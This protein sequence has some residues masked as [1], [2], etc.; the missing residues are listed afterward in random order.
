MSLLVILYLTRAL[1]FGTGTIPLGEP[2]DIEG[3][4][5]SYA[6]R[7]DGSRL[8]GVEQRHDAP[9]TRTTLHW[10]GTTLSRIEVDEEADGL[11]DFVYILTWS[12]AFPARMVRENAPGGTHTAGRTVWEW[13]WSSDHR[14]AVIAEQLGTQPPHH[15]SI[16]YDEH[17]RLTSIA[18]ERDD[19][20]DRMSAVLTWS[21]DGRLSTQRT[22]YDAYRFEYDAQG[23]IATRQHDGHPDA[24]ADRYSYTCPAR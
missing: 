15:R 13:T 14:T 5:N 11:V 8:L 19:P 9:E 16:E 6:F 2:C 18:L 1:N 17:G 12:G 4:P 21:S 24:G 7:W 3:Y 22:Y 10:S 20:N 23:R